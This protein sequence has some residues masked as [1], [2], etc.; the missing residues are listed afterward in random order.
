MAQNKN[1]L[2][3]RQPVYYELYVPH[4]DDNSSCRSSAHHILEA[5]QA[6]MAG[7]GGSA[8]GLTE[9]LNADGVPEAMRSA[10]R[11]PDGDPGRLER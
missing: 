3:V 10:L 1:C 5:G 9:I 2:P 11:R 6:I 4:E 7:K 8:V